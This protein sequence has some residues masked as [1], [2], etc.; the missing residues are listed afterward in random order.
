MSTEKETKVQLPLASGHDD[1]SVLPS[2]NDTGLH[3]PDKV[4]NITNIT[5][6]ERPGYEVVPCGAKPIIAPV[7][8]PNTRGAKPMLAPVSPPPSGPKPQKGQPSGPKQ[9]QK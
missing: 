6:S 1:V 4:L 5:T 3:A 2:K 7:P 9:S 8:P